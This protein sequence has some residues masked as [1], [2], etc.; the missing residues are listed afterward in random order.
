M[1]SL[2]QKLCNQR[3]SFGKS[4][5]A[6]KKEKKERKESLGLHFSAK[7][8]SLHFAVEINYRYCKYTYGFNE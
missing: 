4:C 8:R 7:R 2:E 5:F 6:K 3:L 1:S